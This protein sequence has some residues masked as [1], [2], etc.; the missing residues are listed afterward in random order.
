MRRTCVIGVL[1]VACAAPARAERIAPAEAG[2]LEPPTCVE[3]WTWVSPLPQGNGLEDVTFSPSAGWVGVGLGGA[4]VV[5][6]DGLDW[7]IADT[8]LPP[9]VDLR[10]VTWGDGR[11]VAVGGRRLA[12][13]TALPVVVASTDGRVWTRHDPAVEPSG[14]KA[15]EVVAWGGARFV[16]IDRRGV[17]WTSPDLV[18]WSGGVQRV[19]GVNVFRPE[20]LVWTGSELVAVGSGQR[21]QPPTPGDVVL[22]SLDGV[23]WQFRFQNSGRLLAVATH[24]DT[25]VAVGTRGTVR[26]VGEAAWEAGQATPGGVELRGVGWAGDRFVAVG[27]GSSGNQTR[28]AMESLDG[29]L[30]SPVAAGAGLPDSPTG[31]AEGSTAG[32]PSLVAVGSRG[33]IAASADGRAWDRRSRSVGVYFEDVTWTGDLWVGVTWVGEIVTSPDGIAWR[34]EVSPTTQPLFAVAS[35]AGRTVA[36][37]LREVVTSS[38]GEHWILHRDGIEAALLTVV[39]DGRRFLAAGSGEDGGVVLASPDGET[40]TR[41]DAGRLPELQDLVVVESGYYAFQRW[42]PPL[43]SRDGAQWSTADIASCFEPRPRAG[44]WSGRQLAGVG[45]SSAECDVAC[46]GCCPGLALVSSDLATWSCTGPVPVLA[47]VVWDGRRFVAVGECGAIVTS[48]D[49]TVWTR[50]RGFVDWGLAAV[51][52]SPTAVVVVGP[53]TILTRATCPTAR[54]VRPRLTSPPR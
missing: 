4:I 36:V 29:A 47:D 15:L 18:S 30:W 37:G 46:C 3:T 24:G 28:L 32:S 22:T 13:G 5:S 21:G 40:W 31:L 51:G 44:A 10:A 8:R 33:Q 23:I 54:P 6:A 41:L 12:A 25:T 49:G 1:L 7:T 43:T 9:D 14:D 20:D 42:G 19:A 35:G 2:R 16:A 53:D 17:W 45:S 26:R 38:D 39:W 52:A 11:F 48:P 27:I 50:E 34:H